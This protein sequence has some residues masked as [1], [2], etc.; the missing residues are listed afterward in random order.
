MPT[1]VRACELREGD[2]LCFADSRFNV[3]IEAI[4]ETR[5]GDLRFHFNDDTASTCRAPDDVVLAER[6]GRVL[7]PRL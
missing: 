6:P 1:T 3:V 5:A 2:T 4:T 7:A